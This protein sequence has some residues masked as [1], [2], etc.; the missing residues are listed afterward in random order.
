M[1]SGFF[2]KARTSMLGS[3]FGS[4]QCVGSEEKGR[5]SLAKGMLHSEKDDFRRQEE[6]ESDTRTCAWPPVSRALSPHAVLPHSDVLRGQLGS[7]LK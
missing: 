6:R 4:W 2:I 1:G 3:S 7:A 5:V